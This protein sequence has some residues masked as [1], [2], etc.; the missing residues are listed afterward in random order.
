MSLGS[1][2]GLVLGAL[3]LTVGLALV[4]LP[5]DFQSASPQTVN[6]FKTSNNAAILRVQ[7]P[8]ANF[9]LGGGSLTVTWTT[10]TSTPVEGYLYPLAEGE[11]VWSGAQPSA[12]ALDEISTPQSDWSLKASSLS[13][14]S[15]YALVLYE[16]S[17]ENA[18]VAVT[19][20]GSMEL[21]YAELGVPLAGTGAII[22]VATVALS[23]PRPTQDD[24]SPT[25]AS[26]PE[27]Y[28]FASTSPM[29]IEPTPAPVAALPTPEPRP[30]FSESP[31][32]LAL[33]SPSSSTSAATPPSS[34][35]M[36]KIV[37]PPDEPPPARKGWRATPLGRLGG[38]RSAVAPQSE[39][40]PGR[41]K[42]APGGGGE[43][44]TIPAAGGA[45]TC[46]RCG[47]QIPEES[48]LF[49]PRCRAEL[50]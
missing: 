9:S 11:A 38:D 5:L 41:P 27:A 14:G 2:V 31:P 4:L 20:S 43:T 25:Y 40:A 15:W 17:N 8:Y 3:T 30:A 7:V 26:S 16:N 28:A 50:E 37:L 45:G 1:T 12:P 24:V 48:W 33:P 23:R 18:S 49:C 32:M 22:L 44:A 35:T 13:P 19:W 6:M 34:A 36:S 47:L 21:P 42:V 39:L 29:V 46:P 10:S